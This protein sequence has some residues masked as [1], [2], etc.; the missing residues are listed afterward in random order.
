[1]KT[2]LL[3]VFVFVL[4][5]VLQAQTTFDITWVT[6][7]SVQDASV[8]IEEGDTVRWTW[9]KDGMPHDV[10]SIDPNA[11]GDFGSAI[12]SDIGSVYEYTFDNAV[13]FDYRCSVHPTD[14]NGTITVEPAMSV[15][16]KFLKNLKYYPN[17]ANDYLV[18]TSLFPISQYEI[19]TPQGRKV[20]GE[21][22]DS[23][24]L[25]QLD[26]SGLTPGIYFVKVTAG[27]QSGVVK[28]IKK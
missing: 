10:S 3:V 26:M 9:G 17:P 7:I 15:E 25:L 18:I 1:M 5:G 21:E 20:S 22:I 2:I 14:M 11:P 24:N 6:G 27:N 28:I 19:F 16:D 23:K 4:S 13:V 8:T 12:M